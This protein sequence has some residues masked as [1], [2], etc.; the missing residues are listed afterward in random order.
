MTGERYPIEGQS[1]DRSVG[2][3]T[4]RMD[5]KAACAAAGVKN[6]KL[7]DLRAKSATDIERE[8]GMEHAQKLQGPPSVAA[9]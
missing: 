6:A 4:I 5:W 9:R 3:E 7:H 1:S 2:Y 8:H